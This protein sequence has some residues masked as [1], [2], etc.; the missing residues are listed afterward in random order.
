VIRS[1]RTAN[2][3]KDRAALPELEALSEMIDKKR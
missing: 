2:R 1:K 3:E